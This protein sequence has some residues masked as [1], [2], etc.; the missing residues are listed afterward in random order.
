[1][2]SQLL[3]VMIIPVLLNQV[4]VDVTFPLVI[5]HDHGE[6]SILAVMVLSMV[7]VPVAVLFAM[8]V[9]MSTYVPLAVIVVP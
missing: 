6:Y 9:T 7:N 2:K 8:S 3:L 4:M 1:M 5:D